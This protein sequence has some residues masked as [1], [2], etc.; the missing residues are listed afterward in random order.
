MPMHD[1]RIDTE[2]GGYRIVEPIGQGGTSVVYRAEHVRLGRTAAL[3]LLTPA[4]GEADFHERFLRESKLAA[5]LDHPSIVPVYDAGEADDVL[6]IAMQHIDGSDLKAL[7]VA[8][9]RLPV[10]RALRIIGQ[11][12]S[13]L[14]AAHARGLV[15][16][17]VKPANILIG[18]GDRAFLSDFGVVKELASAGRTRTGG[19]V[20]TIEYCA[21]EQIEGRDVDAR[22]DVYALACVFYECVVGTS[23]FHRSS[24]VATLNAHLHAS[25][26][27]LSKAASDVPPALEPVLAKA[28]A[29]SPLDRYGS[30]GELVADLR[31]AVAERRVYPLR[32]ALS[33]AVL[34]GAA[35]AG[36]AVATTLA[37]GLRHQP[38]PRVTTVVDRQRPAPSPVALDTLVLK[39]T[40]GRTLNDAAFYLITAKEYAR[41]IPFARRAIGYSPK[42]SVTFGYAT[43]NYGFA[44]LKVGR[45]AQAL[46]F[47]RRALHLEAS[48]NR[49]YI[50]PRIT[51]AKACSHG[52]AS[53]PAP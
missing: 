51:Q 9:G 41:A 26:P 32:L 53:G 7:L 12:A 49:R 15:H 21:P 31:A 27:R 36:A 42:G 33:L 34:A 8:E 17:D 35:L 20:G 46:P 13:A 30:C 44:L 50:R 39:S 4:L 11:I 38:S 18:H 22:A 24:D 3:K 16:R 48:D 40:D 47:L 6:Y 1:R 28:L 19:F 5:S 25:P 23:P 14:D 10:R 45:C 2:V 29:K 43:F 52:G 37:L